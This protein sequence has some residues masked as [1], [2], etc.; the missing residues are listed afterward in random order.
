M[1]ILDLVGRVHRVGEEENYFGFV[2]HEYFDLVRYDILVNDALQ[3]KN[4]NIIQELREL[5]L[6]VT[7]NHFIDYGFLILR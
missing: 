6:E 5:N 3:L 7:D 2:K 1:R 4:L